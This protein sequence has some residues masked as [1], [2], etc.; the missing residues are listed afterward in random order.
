MHFNSDEHPAQPSASH[1]VSASGQEE[2]LSVA[3]DTIKNF[4]LV[5]GFAF[6]LSMLLLR[7]VSWWKL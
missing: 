1:I 7:L 2:I 3:I 4:H 5:P 6:P